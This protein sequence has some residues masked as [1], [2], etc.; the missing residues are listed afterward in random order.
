LDNPRKRQ[1]LG[2]NGYQKVKDLYNWDNLSPQF[3]KL[4]ETVK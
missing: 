1:E 4:Y 2:I 3:I